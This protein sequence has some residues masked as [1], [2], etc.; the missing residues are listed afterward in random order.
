MVRPQSDGAPLA[1]RIEALI[2]A[3]HLQPGDRLPS[4]RRMAESFGVSRSRLREAI[5]QFI[6]RGRLVSKQGGGTY[7]ATPHPVDSALAPLASAEMAGAETG[8]WRDV[9]EIRHSLE[10]DAACL[11]ATRAAPA[12]L[13]ALQAAAQAL[14]EAHSDDAATQARLDAEFHL[15]VARAAQNGVLHQLMGGL[16]GLLEASIAD[17]RDAFWQAPGIAE[18][19]DQQHAAICAAICA[20]NPEQARAAALA[21]LSYVEERLGEL[22]EADQRRQRATRTLALHTNAALA[23]AQP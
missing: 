2:A 16:F 8:Y 12:D 21:H 15:A 6:S 5:Q 23:G 18:A 4:E 11:A 3:A 9:M 17:S 7:V 14:A 13:A 10:G 19:L 20:G 1:E 22:A